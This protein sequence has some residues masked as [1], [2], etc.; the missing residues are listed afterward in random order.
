MAQ[1]WSIKEDII[2][3]NFCW[4]CE[5]AYC[6]DN[7]LDELIK[8][9]NK[10]GYV[11]RSR[12]AVQKRARDYEYLYTGHHFPWLTQQVADVYRAVYNKHNGL[13]PYRIMRSYISEVYKEDSNAE[14]AVDWLFDNP[15]N[16]NY[17]ISVEIPE[18]EISFNQVFKT[19]LE[20]FYRER[21]AEN[22]KKLQRKVRQEIYESIGMY[23]NTFNAIRREKYDDVSRRTVMQLCFGLNLNLEESKELMSSAGYKFR[24]NKKADL[25]VMELLRREEKYKYMDINDTL[26]ELANVTL[27]GER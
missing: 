24:K 16:K 18:P 20:R 1:R 27:F 13:G 21:N 7:M 26:Y 10:A 4:E 8:I 2:V 9:L 15:E 25:I 22:D 17:L 5:N 12:T 23:E 3:C 14:V 19:F 11:N 6:T